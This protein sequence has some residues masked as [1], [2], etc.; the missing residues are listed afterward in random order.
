[1]LTQSSTTTNARRNGEIDSAPAVSPKR[2]ISG[3]SPKQATSIDVAQAKRSREKG[4]RSSVKA[5]AT[6]ATEPTKEIGPDTIKI[7]VVDD[8]PLFRHG[9]VQL[10][11]SEKTF[12]VVG[13]ASAAPEA[14]AQ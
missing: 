12:L 3:D 1:M 13:E 4:P 9:L 11:N 8:H 6:A 5:G 7:L 2:F 14:L 10:L